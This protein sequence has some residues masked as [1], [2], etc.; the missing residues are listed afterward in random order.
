MKKKYTRTIAGLILCAAVICYAVFSINSVGENMQ[1]LIPA[2][3]M[4]SG[5]AVPPGQDDTQAVQPD[6]N[7]AVK[8]LW[9]SLKT[10]AEE[11]SGVMR[12]YTLTGIMEGASFTSDI[13]ET[14][15]AR[16]NAL[17]ES[18]FAV[19]PQ[20]LLFGRLLHPE[21]LKNGGKV[22]LLD[23]KLALA[24][25]QI[26]QPIGRTVT[27]NGTDYQVMGVLRN[28][29]KVGDS[30]EYSAYVP[31]S[32]L[33]GES[34]QLDALMVNAVPK[35]G[36]GAR[37]SFQA[38]TSA[39]TSGGTVIDLG[40]EA[41]GNKMPVRI[42][43]FWLGLSLVLRAI[44]WWNGHFLAFFADYKKRLVSSYAIRLFPRLMTGILILSAGYGVLAFAAS[45]LIQFV[46][47]PVYTFPEWVPAI[48]VEWEDIQTAFWKVWQ[49]AAK[50]R[51][52]RSPEI[53]RMQFFGMLLGWFSA[54]FAVLATKLMNKLFRK[55]DA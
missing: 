25:F 21:E 20:Y 29:K 18:A 39:W 27:F 14:K 6:P 49:G 17:G 38:V 45:Y 52:L 1:Y 41:M 10:Q 19:V 40:K 35:K 8:T 11:W 13:G 33:Y 50:M 23:E 28:G 44:S 22:I 46:V 26:S 12:A 5:D 55:R 9:E 42:L 53:I 37:S 4:Q 43:L 16:L 54:G 30:E 24:L 47:E 48:L 36:V 51:E 34:V 15:Q 32:T 3:Q 31:L 7:A 2:P